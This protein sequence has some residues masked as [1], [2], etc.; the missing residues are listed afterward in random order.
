MKDFNEET[1]AV[2]QLNKFIWQERLVNNKG[3]QL[4]DRGIGIENTSFLW[5]KVTGTYQH[6]MEKE[7]LN[8]KLVLEPFRPDFMMGNS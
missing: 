6:S 1:M 8:I 3:A 4:V 7:I 2:G 5:K